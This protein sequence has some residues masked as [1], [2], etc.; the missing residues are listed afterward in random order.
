MN[1]PGLDALITGLAQRWAK[2]QGPT[3][4]ATL[5]AWNPAT[6]HRI[7]LVLT[8]GLGDAIFSSAVIDP[9]K[10]L[11][12]QAE[13]GLLVRHKWQ[14]LYAADSR[15][16]CVI[17]YYGKY[18]R[19]WQTW[20]TLRRFNADLTL[21]LH[22][23]DPDVLPLLAFA[24]CRYLVRV[25]VAGT[26]YPYL[27]ANRL[28]PADQ[29][30]M[31]G[32]HYVENRLRI[33]D[34]L[35]TP[36]KLVRPQ[37]GWSAG[38]RLCVGPD[39]SASLP[40]TLQAWLGGQPYLVLHPHAADRYKSWPQ[41]EL[42]Q[43]LQ[44][45]QQQGVRVIITGTAADQAILAPTL[46]AAQAALSQQSSA[47]VPVW[48][49]CVG[50]LNLAQMLALLQRATLVIAPD[51]GILHAAAALG[52]PVLGLYAATDAAQV[53]PRRQQSG[54]LVQVLQRPQTCTPCLEKKC[55]YLIPLC[56]QQLTADAVWHATHSLLIAAQR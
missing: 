3:G 2:R 42:K 13:F 26:R 28:Q 33:L 4:V 50:E 40:A 37:A 7:L 11:F 21:V 35:C 25:P 27:L 32:W 47:A 48:R 38:P 1:I 9:L 45:C 53:G 18:R 52:R 20:R 15:L 16:H 54:Q 8:T 49:S 23:N 19:Y 56:M 30:T 17:P 22:A 29:Q 12:P 31:P 24:G 43:F 36:G 39:S 6:T 55:P 5:D 34:S 44:H 46:L 51:T 14:A 41:A 10:Q